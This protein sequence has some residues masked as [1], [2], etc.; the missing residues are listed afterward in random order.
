MRS[1][2]LAIVTLSAIALAACGGGGAATTP[3]GPAVAVELSDFKFAPSTIEIPA[4]QK[5]T[6][7][8]KNKGSVEHDVTVDAVG[9]KAIVRGG[10][11]ATRAIGP[12]KAG[13]YDFY[14][15]V[16]GHKESGMVGKLVV[17]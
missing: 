3:A 10:Q 12:L 15:S 6:L 1:I 9:F 16:A 13:T 5:V 2:A 11:S 14:C 4:D 7:E 8:L 17:K